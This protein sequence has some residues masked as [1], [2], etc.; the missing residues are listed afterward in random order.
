VASTISSALTGSIS[1]S[2]WFQPIDILYDTNREEHCAGELQIVDY[3]AYV[4]GPK[5]I[6]YTI[7]YVNTP[8]VIEICELGG[9]QHKCVERRRR[10]PPF[11]GPSGIRPAPM[12]TRTKDIGCTV[13]NRGEVK[14]VDSKPGRHQPSVVEATPQVLTKASETIISRPSD[15]S[16]AASRAS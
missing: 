1:S 13:G 4:S 14:G 8:A 7:T 10:S 15:F 6:F 12:P 9:G 16:P 5:A 11:S 2:M 3:P